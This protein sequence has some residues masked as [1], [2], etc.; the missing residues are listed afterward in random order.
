MLYDVVLSRDGRAQNLYYAPFREGPNRGEYFFVDD[1]D[2][3]AHKADETFSGV[4]RDS[5]LWNMLKMLGDCEI[6]KIRSVIHET[7]MVYYEEEEEKF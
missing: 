3:T 6:Y 1:D 7:P 5:N 2:M 4:D